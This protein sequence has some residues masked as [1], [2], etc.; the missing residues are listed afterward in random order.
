MMVK[1][2]MD[3]QWWMDRF[4]YWKLFMEG[5]LDGD[6]ILISLLKSCTTISDKS[7]QKN[8]WSTTRW[9]LA[10]AF[11]TSEAK[12]LSDSA[13]GKSI[14]MSFTG[15]FILML[16]HQNSNTKWMILININYMLKKFL[17]D[18][19]FFCN[20]KQYPKLLQKY[21]F[22][23]E[24]QGQNSECLPSSQQTTCRVNVENK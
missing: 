7:D 14:L 6:G 22:L 12:S 5:W 15:K 10:K 9:Q 4:L 18:M 17:S 11:P 16:P 20:S 13:E 2:V 21:F 24:T 1:M 3:G 19:Y 23:S 8:G